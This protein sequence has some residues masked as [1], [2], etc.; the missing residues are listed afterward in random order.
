MGAT[1]IALVAVLGTGC[2]KVADKVA[3]KAAEKAAEKATGGS[4]NLNSSDGGVSVKTKDGSATFGSGAKLP[5]GWPADV[6]LPTGT[7][8]VSSQSIKADGG[9]S[10]AV[11]GTLSKGSAESIYNSFQS[12]LKDAGYSIDNNYAA[13]NSGVYSGGFSATK[14]TT[15]VTVSV[16]DASSSSK[17]GVTIAVT[18]SPKN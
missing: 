9:T 18:V 13:T 5:D 3:N 11:T 10:F 15:G 14:G 16:T 6:K 1:A 2:G 4:V 8:L 12:T 7:V 17:S